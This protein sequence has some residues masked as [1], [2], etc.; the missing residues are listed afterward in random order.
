MSPPDEVGTWSDNIITSWWHHQME[1][2]SALL[3]LYPGYSLVTV[4]FPSQSFGVLFEKL[5][6]FCFSTIIYLWGSFLTDGTFLFLNTAIHYI[7]SINKLNFANDPSHRTIT[8]IYHMTFDISI[9]ISVIHK[10]FNVI[11]TQQLNEYLNGNCRLHERNNLSGQL[12]IT[13]YGIWNS[14]IN[15][16]VF[17]DP[18]YMLR[19]GLIQVSYSGS[20]TTFQYE[21][22]FPRCGFPITM[23]RRSSEAL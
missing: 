14:E 5:I 3:V 19:K 22:R 1:T 21:N 16:V 23:M 9:M 4:E 12:F 8:N 7:S 13:W 18:Y 2:F 17:F 10:H 6:F 15:R 11:L 20:R